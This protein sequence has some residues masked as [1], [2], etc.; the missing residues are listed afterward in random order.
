MRS[1]NVEVDDDVF[2]FVKEHAEPLV[3]NFSSTLR[4]LLNIGGKRAGPRTIQA[5]AQSRATTSILPSLP[6]GLP[7]ALRQPLEVTY[8]VRKA[9]RNRTD[10]TH[11][12]AKHH[13]VVPQTI[14]DKYTR[15]LDLTAAQFDELLDQSNLADLRKRL[16][17]KYP[18]HTDFI[19]QVLAPLAK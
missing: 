9:G 7:E 18:S 13:G 19:E 5:A 6:R 2:A 10:A 4:R 1:H 8:L 3:D 11:F 15:R 14:L 12:A 16:K 17:Q